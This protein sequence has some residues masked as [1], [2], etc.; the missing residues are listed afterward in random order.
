[1]FGSGAL[2]YGIAMG[3]ATTACSFGCNPLL[4]IALGVAVLKGAT[5]LGAAMLTIFAVGYSVPLTVGLVGV[6]YGVGRLGRIT[7]HVLPSVR[8]AGGILMIVV[9]FYLLA[10]T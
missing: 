8:I 5:V 6:G 7:E 10:G 2:A 1:M 4:P 3:G 9:G